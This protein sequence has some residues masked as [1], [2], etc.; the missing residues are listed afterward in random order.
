MRPVDA[1]RYAELAA[2]IADF[3]RNFGPLPSLEQE[4]NR[5]C[6]LEHLLESIR[7]VK[8]F[9][10][11]LDRDI[12]EVRCDPTHRAFDP[13]R[14]AI[15]YHRAGMVDEAF[16][17]IF[18]HVHFGKHRR[19]GWRLVADVYAGVGRNHGWSWH[20]V[21]SDADGFLAWLHANRR[22]WDSASNRGRFGN[23]RKYESLDAYSP[24]GTGAVVRSY[25]EW[26]SGS[27]SHKELIRKASAEVGTD[28]SGLFDYLFK[29]MRAVVRFGRTAKFDYLTTV[30]NLGLWKIRPGSAYLEGATGPVRGARL[31]F[32]G[33]TESK[34]QSLS[35]LQ[36]GLDRLDARLEVGMQVLEDSLCNWQKSPARFHPFRG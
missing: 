21:C 28:P 15:R 31:L 26:T 3:E 19:D 16:W 11:L 14:A 34:S 20:E 4:G 6:L 23:H 8:Y 10:V 2:R 29:D 9:H 25:V 22:R 13:L 7:R 36:I 18:L 30:G 33:N 24:K 32:L 35:E 5:A 27:G 1:N 17:L 12:S